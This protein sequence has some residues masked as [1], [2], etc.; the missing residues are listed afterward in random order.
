[1]AAAAIAIWLSGAAAAS[2]AVEGVSA[3]GGS[4]LNSASAAAAAAAIPTLTSIWTAVVSPVAEVLHHMFMGWQHCWVVMTAHPS[5]A[6]LQQCMELLSK[7]GAA[8][9]WQIV[10]AVVAVAATTISIRRQLAREKASIR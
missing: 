2:Q 7:A 4:T 9:P 10:A 6:G 5:M 3:A 1:M 8:V